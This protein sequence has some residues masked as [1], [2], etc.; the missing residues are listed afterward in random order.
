LFLEKGNEWKGSIKYNRNCRFLR[1][2]IRVSWAINIYMT[3]R[4]TILSSTKRMPWDPK[5]HRSFLLKYFSE[6][7]SE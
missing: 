4:G 7:F 1:R 3:E 2:Q 6:A 5:S